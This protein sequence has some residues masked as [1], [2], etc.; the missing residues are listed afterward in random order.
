[1]QD[2]RIALHDQL[3]MLLQIFGGSAGA[4]SLSHGRFQLIIRSERIVVI[5]VLKR[6]IIS[7]SESMIFSCPGEF[8]YEVAQATHWSS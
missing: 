1:V 5:E 8:L 4:A 6:P 7:N 2:A 3:A